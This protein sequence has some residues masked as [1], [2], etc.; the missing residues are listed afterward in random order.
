MTVFW[1]FL[2]TQSVI[3]RAPVVDSQSL[4]C[5]SGLKAAN[6]GDCQRCCRLKSGSLS[7]QVRQGGVVLPMYQREALWLSFSAL[8]DCAVKIG[9]GGVNALTGEAL[10]EGLTCPSGKQAYVACPQQPWL[11][12]VC[13]EKGVVR[14]F[15]A[16]PL[17][18]GYSVEHQVTGKET[19]GGLQIEVFPRLATDAE[20]TLPNGGSVSGR[21]MWASPADL[22]LSAGG[23][24]MLRSERMRR[25]ALAREE[26]LVPGATLEVDTGGWRVF[27]A[28]DGGEVRAAIHCDGDSL[29]TET[30]TGIPKESTLHMVL[31]LRGGGDESAGMGIAAGGRIAQV[32][33]W[34]RVW[35]RC[36]CRRCVVQALQCAQCARAVGAAAG[37]C[38]RCWRFVRCRRF[39]LRCAGFKHPH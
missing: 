20:F 37:V 21:R 18:Q 17:G 19:H 25:P 27:R 24:L 16:M 38:A 6:L 36:C 29:A 33:W 32:R 9:V 15:V 5:N 30:W 1:P 39:C 4:F 35:C 28:A 26:G 3:A 22:G 23:V 13:L 31:R 8:T 7:F 14:Q 2:G 12:G 10:R 34:W 11:D